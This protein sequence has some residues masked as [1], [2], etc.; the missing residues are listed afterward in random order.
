MSS[1]SGPRKIP[2]DGEVAEGASAVDE[3]MVTGES[4]P[5]EK[6]PGDE[7]IGGTLSRPGLPLPHDEVGKDTALASII[8]LVQDAQA[9]RSRSSASW[10]WSPA[11]FTPSV[12]ILA[13]LGFMLWYTF[14]PG[15]GSCTR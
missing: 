7:V 8:R 15:P 6:R 4:M 14:G 1:S 13:I 10:T 5:V 12:A 11:T 9:P 3:S 2:V